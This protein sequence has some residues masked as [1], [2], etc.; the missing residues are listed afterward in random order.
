MNRED[1][2]TLSFLREAEAGALLGAGHFAGAYYLVGYAVECALKA[3]IAK[4]TNQFDFPDRDAAVAAFTHDLERLMKAARLTGDF[5]TTRRTNRR[6]DFNWSTV[7][8]WR[9]TARYETTIREEQATTMLRACTESPSG[10]LNWVR[11][12]W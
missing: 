2:Q 4:Q 11:E 7:R 1:F 6:L 10:I 8:E 3:C 12:R 5:E 9:E